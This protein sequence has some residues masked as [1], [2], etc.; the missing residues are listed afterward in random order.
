MFIDVKI[1][2]NNNKESKNSQRKQQKSFNKTQIKKKEKRKYLRNKNQFIDNDEKDCFLVFNKNKNN[3]NNKI[4]I[5]T[6][7]L[8]R[9]FYFICRKLHTCG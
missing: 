2:K 5:E 9:I 7:F 8:F 4:N 6:F 3:N 1:Q